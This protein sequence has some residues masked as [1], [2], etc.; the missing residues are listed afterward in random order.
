MRISVFI[1]TIINVASK[2]LEKQNC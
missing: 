1:T 2:I